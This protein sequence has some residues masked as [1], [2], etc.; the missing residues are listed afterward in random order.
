MGKRNKAKRQ[1]D[2][3]SWGKARACSRSIKRA[4]IETSD[5]SLR[6]LRLP[7][8]GNKPTQWLAN[9]SITDTR[10]DMQEPNDPSSVFAAKTLPALE[11]Q[12]ESAQALK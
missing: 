10:T 9:S 4:W 5:V 2:E 8:A 12:L 11:R 6:A 7:I 3:A 1:S